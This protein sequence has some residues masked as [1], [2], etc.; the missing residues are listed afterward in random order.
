MTGNSTGS[1]YVPLFYLSLEKTTL[2]LALGEKDAVGALTPQTIT[3]TTNFPLQTWTHVAFSVDST[4]VDMY[5]NGK[6]LQS[7]KLNNMINPPTA[8][9]IYAGQTL[10]AASGTH[11]GG[12][13]M[14][15]KLYRWTNAISPSEVW[16]Q[17]LAGNGQS[18]GA[19]K[20][21]MNIGIVQN[22]SQ[23]ASFRVI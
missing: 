16:S 17:Y 15:A 18:W 20:Y 14:L 13:M 2:K 10:T 19:T 9:A 12:D 6:L 3:I 21:G 22:N 5:L 23:T 4:Y 11:V 8:T 1:T 7:A